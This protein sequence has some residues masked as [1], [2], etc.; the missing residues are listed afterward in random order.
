MKLRIMKS[1]ALLSL[2]K[3]QWQPSGLSETSH[4]PGREHMSWSKVQGRSSN[5]E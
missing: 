5:I 3:K 1:Q 4:H 2:Q